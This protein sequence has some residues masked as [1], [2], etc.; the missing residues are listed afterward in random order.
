[1]RQSEVAE[2]LGIA[3]GFDKRELAEL[4][5]MAWFSVLE[6]YD[7]QVTRKVMIDWYANKKPGDY[8]EVSDLVRGVKF[9]TRQTVDQIETDVRTAKARGLIEQSWPA[10]EPLPTEVVERLAAARR[11]DQ[12][13]YAEYEA[14]GLTELPPGM[15]RP[16]Y[17]AVG[18]RVPRA[19]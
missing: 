4:T 11:R 16:D 8:L 3:H 1:V 5:E 18:R 6:P 14:I 13:M 10:R 19:E 7:F 17:G 2:L 15:Q 9:A 12:A